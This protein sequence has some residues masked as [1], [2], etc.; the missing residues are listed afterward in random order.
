MLIKILFWLLVAVD[1]GA[2]GLFLVLGLAAAGP[3]H[4]NPL[5]VVWWM[6]I[7]PGM[8]LAL[9][10]VLFLFG[11]SWLLRGPAFLAA[12]APLL[13]VVVWGATETMK[14]NTFKDKDGAIT[15]FAGGSMQELEKAIVRN[16]AAAV[17]TL[18]KGADLNQTGISGSGVLVVALRQ[19]GRTGGPP[20][21]LRALLAAG[22]NPN[23]KTGERPLVVALQVSQR[24]GVEPVQMLLA[25]KADPNARSQFGEPVFFSGVGE[26]VDPATLPL[27]LDGGAD[28]AATSSNGD[29]LLLA[30]AQFRN[31]DAALVLLRRGIQTKNGVSFRA[32]VEAATQTSYKQ[33]GLD[34]LLAY[35]KQREK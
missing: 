11:N 24:T 2:M 33:P 18:A 14:L 17:G 26:G 20:D 27:L 4:T 31:W 19:L 10:I 5:S 30:A 21:V 15:S 13:I 3:S 6:A 9:A 29:D 35:L 22:A 28:L 8:L 1:L 25:A 34:G 12:A 23:P 32:K 7:L 16:D